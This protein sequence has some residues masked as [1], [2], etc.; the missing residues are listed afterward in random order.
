[1]DSSIVKLIK[2][3]VVP[4]ADN[5]EQIEITTEMND[6][7]LVYNLHVSA[8]DAGRIIGK[9]GRVAQAI[10]TVVYSQNHNNDQRI[11]LNI[12]PE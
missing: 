12:I 4:L 7:C 1:M 10:R 6:D 3:I 11:K 8:A 2:A 9:H 5:K